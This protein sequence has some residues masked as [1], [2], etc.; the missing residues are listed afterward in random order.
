[1]R[2]IVTQVLVL[3]ATASAAHAQFWDK[4]SNPTTQV[5]LHHPPGLGLKINKVAFGAASGKCADQIVEAVVSDFVS[6]QVEVIDRQNLGA[7]LAE[8]NLTTSGYVDQS[9]AAAIGRLLGPSALV[10]VRTQRCVTSQDRLYDTESRYDPRTKSN[11]NVR[12]YYSRTRAF[13]N[14]SIQTVDLATGRIFAARALTYSPEQSNKS[15]DGYPEAPAEFDVLDMA[16]KAAVMDFHRMFLPWSEQTK[17]VFFD[18]KDCGLK[19]AFDLLKA[20]DVEGAFHAS[21]Q[22][23]DTCKSAA[24]VKDKVLGHAYYNLGMSYM[25]RDQY[26]TALVYFQEAAKLR[27][28]EI[29]NKALADCQAARNMMLAM[30]QI[31]QRAAFETE[32]T[33]GEGERTAQAEAATTLSNADVIQMVR[34][35]LSDA[36]IV[37]KIKSSKHKFDTSA[38]ALVVL[39]KAGVSEPV[40]M[41]MMEP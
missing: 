32:R 17:L 30:Q 2:R 15:E 41:A 19:Q 22:N 14:A 12:V 3:F 37:H 26:D 29:V 25:M 33:R 27:P 6:Q 38:D 23:L 36:I 8:H 11:Y 20:Q 1:M 5:T 31:E 28:G 39:T 7:L 24:K 18:D 35:R 40:I 13:L 34:N 16:I 21:Q 9:S 10:F 4:L